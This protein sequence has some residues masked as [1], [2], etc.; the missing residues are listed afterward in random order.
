MVFLVVAA[1]AL[2]LSIGGTYAYL[3]YTTNEVPNAM[4]TGSVKVGVVENDSEVS[5]STNTAN[6][7]ADSKQVALKNTGTASEY[8]RV[9]FMPE[10]YEADSTAAEFTDQTWPATFTGTTLTLGAA[11]LYFADDWSSNWTY[12]NG[13]FY[14][15]SSIAVGAQTAV[16]LK[17]VTWTDGSTYAN[18]GY[19]MKVN[20]IADAIQE[21]AAAQ[22]W[23]VT[24]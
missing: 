22:E 7:G 4:S 17:G 2:V 19:T 18:G 9:T 21:S 5:G 6:L 11:T 23:G 8:V 14:S 13:T 15:K 12:D 3:T 1:I 24:S 20:V 10:I 16:L